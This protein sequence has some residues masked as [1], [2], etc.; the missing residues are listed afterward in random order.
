ME[1]TREVVSRFPEE[2]GP[3]G[4]AWKVPKGRVAIIPSVWLCRGVIAKCTARVGSDTCATGTAHLIALRPWRRHDGVL[5]H[6]HMH[7]G[8]EYPGLFLARD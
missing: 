6:V 4:G 2:G 8:F 5:E 3:W 1:V 7:R